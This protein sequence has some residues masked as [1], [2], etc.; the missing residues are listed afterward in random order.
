M[1]QSNSRPPNIDLWAVGS[2]VS[3]CQPPPLQTLMTTIVAELG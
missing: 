1:A 2:A 3:W